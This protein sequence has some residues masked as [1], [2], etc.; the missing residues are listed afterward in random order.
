M[1]CCHCSA[2]SVALPFCWQQQSL[3]CLLSHA[4]MPFTAHSVCSH[5]WCLC[6]SPLQSQHCTGN[7]VL[8]TAAAFNAV[9]PLQCTFSCIAILLAAAVTSVSAQSCQHAFHCTFSVQSPVVPLHVTTA[10]TALHWQCSARDGS[11]I[12]C[13]AAIAVH[14]QLHCHS[15]GSSS[16]FSVCSVMPACLS[17]HIQ[18]AVTSGAF[19]CHHCS[20]SIAL[21]MQCS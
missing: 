21:A 8:V 10:V 20:H 12:Q 16:H 2:L 19:A 6:M 17:L 1:L 13:C 3:Q 7:A 9:L 14:F 11:S 15:A 18:C 4:S 5:Q